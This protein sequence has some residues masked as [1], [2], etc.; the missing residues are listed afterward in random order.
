MRTLRASHISSWL[1]AS[2]TTRWRRQR[3]LIPSAKSTSVCN[4]DIQTTKM[5][6]GGG[7]HL[8]RPCHVPYIGGEDENLGRGALAE[9]RVSARLERCL[10]ASHQGELG[11]GACVLECDLCTDAARSASDQH[12]LPRECLCIE[13]HLGVDSRIDTWDYWLQP[14]RKRTRGQERGRVR[15]TLHVWRLQDLHPSRGLRAWPLLSR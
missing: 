12:H 13:M 8:L 10:A 14:G 15:L 7:D 2:N 3:T 11:T 4:K 6:H 5:S 1:G 9:D